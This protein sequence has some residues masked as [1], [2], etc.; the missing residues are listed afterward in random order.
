MNFQ[1]GGARDEHLHVVPGG[2]PGPFPPLS[3]PATLD[4]PRTSWGAL[5]A[6]KITGQ[7]IRSLEARGVQVINPVEKT[8]ACGDIGT[9]AMESV[10]NIAA[11][12]VSALRKQHATEAPA[13]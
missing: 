11:V 1:G 4:C 10:E 7:H 12:I 5:P 2:L 3:G 9:G 8:L 6:Q 13:T